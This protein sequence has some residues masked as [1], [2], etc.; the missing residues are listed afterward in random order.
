MEST[1]NRTPML[2]ISHSSVTFGEATER[3]CDQLWVHSKDALALLLERTTGRLSY[4]DALRLLAKHCDI[5]D[6]IFTASNG[7]IIVLKPNKII[8]ST[9]LRVA[10]D[11]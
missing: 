9:P 8:R 10:T 5:V 4:D 6:E 7:V 11:D 1:E 3:Y 2:V